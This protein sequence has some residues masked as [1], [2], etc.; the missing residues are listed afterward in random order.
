MYVTVVMK[1]QH[2]R[3]RLYDC[4]MEHFFICQSPVSVAMLIQSGI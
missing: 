2:V 4:Q 1:G 3:Q